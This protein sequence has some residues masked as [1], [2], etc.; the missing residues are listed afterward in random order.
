MEIHRRTSALSLA[1]ADRLVSRL[2]EAIDGLSH[3][4]ELGRALPELPDN[5]HRD[6]IVGDYRVVYRIEHDAAIIVTVFHGRQLF[7]PSWLNGNR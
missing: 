7:R 1:T 2:V 4:P 3:F 5:T 6:V